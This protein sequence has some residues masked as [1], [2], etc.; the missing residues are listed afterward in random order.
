LFGRDIGSHDG[1]QVPV[2][3]VLA[4]HELAGDVGVGQS[5][6]GEFE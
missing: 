5:L 3:G 2:H 4:A 6:W 1:C